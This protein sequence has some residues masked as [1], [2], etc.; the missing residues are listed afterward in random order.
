MREREKA[1]GV[2][3]QSERRVLGSVVAVFAGRGSPRIWLW[4]CQGSLRWR[5]RPE[6]LLVLLLVLILVLFLGRP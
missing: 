6:H 4:R 2:G 1:R 5:W 3:S